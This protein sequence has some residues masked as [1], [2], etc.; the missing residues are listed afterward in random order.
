MGLSNAMGLSDAGCCGGALV[1][2]GCCVRFLTVFVIEIFPGLSR[3][4]REFP[5]RIC[6]CF[7]FSSSISCRAGRCADLRK[8]LVVESVKKYVSSVCRIEQ[9]RG[10]RSWTSMD[11]ASFKGRQVADELT[12]N[13]SEGRHGGSS[14]LYSVYCSE[15]K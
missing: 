6:S 14:V 11:G 12:A 7:S 13:R 4:K 10:H 8:G 9:L 1:P 2:S 5:P 15:V 3:H